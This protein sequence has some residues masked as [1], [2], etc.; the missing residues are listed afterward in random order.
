MKQ[1][2]VASPA[3]NQ[4]IPDP[5]GPD[6]AELERRRRVARRAFVIGTL[7]IIVAAAVATGVLSWLGWR[8]EPDA[9]AVQHAEPPPRIAVAAPTRTAPAKDRALPGNAQPLMEAALYARVTGYVSLR[10]V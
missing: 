1:P 3:P 4:P 10:H 9:S 6:P 7:G 2:D 5:P 8:Q